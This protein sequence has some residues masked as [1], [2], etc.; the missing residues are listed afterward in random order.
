VSRWTRFI[1]ALRRRLVVLVPVAVLGA[2]VAEIPASGA[3]VGMV[4]AH[5]GDRAAAPEN[6]LAAIRS[7]L[8]K[9]ADAVEIDVRWTRSGVPVILHDE[10]LGRTT[11]CAGL[12]TEWTLADLARCDAGSWFDERFRGERVPTL[13]AALAE[14]ALWSKSAL[15]IVHLKAFTDASQ[16]GRIMETVVGR[17]M[18]DRTVFIADDPEILKQ[19][20]GAGAERL[21]YIFYWAGSWDWNFP[22]MIPQDYALDRELVLAAQRRGVTVW[23]IEGRPA[24]LTGLGKLAPIDGVLVND[25]DSLRPSRPRED[26]TAA[27][28][29]LAGT[30]FSAA[31]EDVLS[32]ALDAAAPASPPRGRAAPLPADMPLP[33]STFLNLGHRTPSTARSGAA[34]DAV[35][36]RRAEDDAP[37]RH[38]SAGQAPPARQAASPK[39]VEPA[40]LEPAPVYGPMPVRREGGWRPSGS[41]PGRGAALGS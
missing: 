36:Q 39:Y 33:S 10:G 4:I 29:A 5:R 32:S 12:V 11:D 13:K 24:G 19:M 25:L 17:G 41:L 21:G 6:T 23:A 1:A 22:Y 7:A 31:S 18:A 3:P 40:L 38:E 30:D 9:G 8:F 35:A 27:R 16:P 14:V 34:A 28:S 2:L 15:A 37:G 26:R 20:R